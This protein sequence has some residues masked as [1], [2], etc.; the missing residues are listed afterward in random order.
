MF[1]YEILKNCRICDSNS[2]I[3]ILDLGSQPPANSLTKTNLDEISK[4]PLELMY[5]KNCNTLQLSSTINP[6][7]LFKDYV[8]VTGTSK[9][10]LDYSLYFA[11]EVLNRSTK[12]NPF[13]LEIAS[14]DG[15]F[16][17]RFKA[18]GCNILGVDPASNIS[19]EAEKNGIPTINS[20]FNL[21]EAKNIRKNSMRLT[22]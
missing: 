2:I 15:T 14:N 1:N 20:F 6:K 9:A 10:A 22:L 11:E 19:K 8:W 4:V 12:T 7:V 21:Q 5:C 13:V 18:K 3:S 17:N 16:L